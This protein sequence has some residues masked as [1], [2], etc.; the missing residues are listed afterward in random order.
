MSVPSLSSSR[1]SARLCVPIFPSKLH[2]ILLCPK[3]NPSAYTVILPLSN[4]K[5]LWV[6]N[7]WSPIRSSLPL[8][9]TRHK[10][11][12]QSRQQEDTNGDVYREPLTFMVWFMDTL[13]FSLLV[14]S[15]KFTKTLRHRIHSS[16]WKQDR[17]QSCAPNVPVWLWWLWHRTIEKMTALLS[18]WCWMFIA[19]VP[20]CKIKRQ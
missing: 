10:P 7:D 15:L 6:F 13:C 11:Q 5:S 12:L 20:L 17:W 9:P 4:W 1:D 3:Q 8:R 14:I 2:H 19:I 16:P 18:E